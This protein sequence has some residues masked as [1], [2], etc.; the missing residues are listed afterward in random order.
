MWRSR[1]TP[2]VG[3]QVSLRGNHWPTYCGVLGHVFSNVFALSQSQLLKC[4]HGEQG[5]VGVPLLDL[6]LVPVPDK[7]LTDQ[8]V[9]QGLFGQIHFVPI[10]SPIVIF[11]TPRHN[12]C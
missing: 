10:F 8:L 4:L 9:Q 11:R 5:G 3:R 7:G 6:H 12:V 2:K 1:V